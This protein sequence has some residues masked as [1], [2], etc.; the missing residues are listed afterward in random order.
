[1]NAAH[2]SCSLYLRK[3]IVYI[4]TYGYDGG[5]WVEIEP[6]SAI[7][8]TNAVDLRQAIRK[9]IERG[10]PIIDIRPGTHQGSI[11]AE[12]AG[13]RSWSAFMRDATSF[14]LSRRKNSAYKIETYRKMARGSAYEP[15]DS[16]TV[17][18]PGD[19][20]IDQVCD[21]MIEILQ[22]RAESGV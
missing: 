6:V 10:S 17:V 3:G 7:P 9:T 2:F 4:T 12:H 19:T 16:Q 8:L 11:V 22:K 1:M 5:L 20:D 15:D 13:I 18:L 14:S 21:R